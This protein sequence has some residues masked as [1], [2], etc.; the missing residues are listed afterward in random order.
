MKM[1]KCVGGTDIKTMTATNGAKDTSIDEEELPVLESRLLT[2][3][4]LRHTASGDWKCKAWEHMASR[5]GAWLK[6]AHLAIP[7]HLCDWSRHFGR[8][9][10]IK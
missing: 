3:R 5:S 9:G 10:R 8:K 4:S 6:A 1:G 7:M 2:L